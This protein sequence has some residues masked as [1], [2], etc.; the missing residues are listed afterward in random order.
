MVSCFLATC[1]QSHR[2]PRDLVRRRWAHLVSEAT[3]VW[4]VLVDDRPA[5]VAP[6]DDRLVVVCGGM[7]AVD[8]TVGFGQITEVSSARSVVYVGD[9]D[10]HC[11]DFT[12]L[13]SQAAVRAALLIEQRRAAARGTAVGS[14]DRGAIE[15][16][17]G[18]R[19]MEPV[20]P[21]DADQ[22]DF[23][24]PVRPEPPTDESAAERD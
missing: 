6:A 10:G 13:D 22:V 7:R 19:A 8:W 18:W 23:G 3:P 14:A 2:R 24:R 4:A 9:D 21:G 5:I 16:W 11:Y 17:E 12:F 1:P 20:G 15:R